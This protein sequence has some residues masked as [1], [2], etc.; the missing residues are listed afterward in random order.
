MHVE[1]PNE[2]E[3][4][5]GTLYLCLSVIVPER[6]DIC[7]YNKTVLCYFNQITEGKKSI[8]VA[9]L[10]SNY[11]PHKL[12]YFDMSM[13]KNIIYKYFVL[14]SCTHCNINRKEEENI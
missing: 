2:G 9:S 11:F 8:Q 3:K 5:E 4:W 13:R 10:T 7:S 12:T 1:V 14:C 6:L